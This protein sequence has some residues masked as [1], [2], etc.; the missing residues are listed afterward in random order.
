[1]TRRRVIRDLEEAKLLEERPLFIPSS[2]KHRGSRKAGLIYEKKVADRLKLLLE[3]YT[4]YHQPWIY[5]KDKRGD[6]WCSPDIVILTNS[7][8]PVNVIGECKLTVTR[9]AERKLR[10]IYLPTCSLIWPEKPFRL[11]QIAKNLRIDW[12]DIMLDGL[13]DIFDPDAEWDFA[14]WN[15]RDL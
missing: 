11:V 12:D 2:K 7:E 8:N 3:D 5:Y 10:N 14:T 6:G 15:W 4:V 13:D 9:A 1:M